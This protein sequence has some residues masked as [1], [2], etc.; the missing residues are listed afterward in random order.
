MC[1][2]PL[3][4][5]YDREIMDTFRIGLERYTVLYFVGW[6]NLN[7]R[8][9]YSV[10]SKISINY[11]VAVLALV[12]VFVGNWCKRCQKGGGYANRVNRL[13]YPIH[14]GSLC[15]STDLP[16][17]IYR[18]TPGHFVNPLIYLCRFT[19]SHRVNLSIHRSTFSDS[20][21]HSG[22]FCDSSCR[23]T[24]FQTYVAL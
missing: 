1:G 17:S 13:I 6:G 12:S 19:D 5:R 11:K 21:I 24:V 18:F 22:Q 14:P 20:P 3:Q 23:F 9:I 8:A 4:K 2:Q 7:P 16:T 15:R 10:K